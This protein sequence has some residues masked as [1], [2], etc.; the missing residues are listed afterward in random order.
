[1]SSS[2]FAMSYVRC[3]HRW[4]RLQCRRKSNSDKERSTWMLSC[5]WK[6]MHVIKGTLLLSLFTHKMT[7][8]SVSKMHGKTR[9]SDAVS[10]N[11]YISLSPSKKIKIWLTICG[12]IASK[13][14]F[15]LLKL[16]CLQNSSVKNFIKAKFWPQKNQQK[17]VERNLKSSISKAV[18]E[19]NPLAI[20]MRNGKLSNS[21]IHRSS[22]RDEITEREAIFN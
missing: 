15:L 3:S 13:L 21:M 11:V 12:R 22:L 20:I 2:H 4:L 17:S 10:L 7:R 1:M 14:A 19:C 6:K 9:S 16:R 5:Q 18:N 8:Q